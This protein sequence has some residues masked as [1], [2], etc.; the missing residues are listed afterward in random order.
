M[1]SADDVIIC[2]DI[3]DFGVSLQE[4][5]AGPQAGVLTRP[6]S[7]EPSTQAQPL[8]TTVGCFRKSNETQTKLFIIGTLKCKSSI[9]SKSGFYHPSPLIGVV[10]LFFLGFAAGFSQNK[11]PSQQKNDVFNPRN[12]PHCPWKHGSEISLALQLSVDSQQLG[13]PGTLK[14]ATSSCWNSMVFS[15]FEAVGVQNVC[16]P[17]SPTSP[18]TNIPWVQSPSSPQHPQKKLQLIGGGKEPIFGG[19]SQ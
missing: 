6:C 2:P 19:S 15:G 14:H 12:P 11:T 13:V 5:R 3:C 8:T 10:F 4:F 17:I 16:S 18:E 9:Y 7:K 1:T